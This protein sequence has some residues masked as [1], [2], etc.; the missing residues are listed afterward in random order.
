MNRETT[1][2][3]KANDPPIGKLVSW[4]IV[5]SISS[6]FIIFFSRRK[7]G[8]GGSAEEK[9]GFA[10]REKGMVWNYHDVHVE[11]IGAESNHAVG[12]GSEICEI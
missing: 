9:L 8:I 10:K 7:T 6:Y 3:A 12:L 11:P 5:I 2:N 1:V 4:V